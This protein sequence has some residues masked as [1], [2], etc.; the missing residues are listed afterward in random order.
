MIESE[1]RNIR[2]T[3]DSRSSK[4]GFDFRILEV[5]TRKVPRIHR[6]EIGLSAHE[7]G[8]RDGDFI[9]S[10]NEKSTENMTLEQVNEEIFSNQNEVELQVTSQLFN[11]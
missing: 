9:L 3:L 1:I 8:L 6:V 2:L 5:G 11:S 4:Y 7:A 10:V